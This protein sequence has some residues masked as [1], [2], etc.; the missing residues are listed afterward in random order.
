MHSKFVNLM[1]I[2]KNFKLDETFFVFKDCDGWTNGF[3][4]DFKDINTKNMWARA[5][6]RGKKC[7]RFNDDKEKGIESSRILGNV[8]KSQEEVTDISF[9]LYPVAAILISARYRRAVNPIYLKYFE[10]TYKRLG[11]IS[12]LMI[13]EL[14]NPIVVYVGEEMFG[15]IM[16]MRTEE[17]DK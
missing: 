16:P 7:Y 3:M 5:I 9:S 11:G 14:G 12:K 13:G 1:S 4:A 17:D 10:S 6:L 15:V 2:T 8:S